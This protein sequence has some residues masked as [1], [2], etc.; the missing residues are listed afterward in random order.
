MSTPRIRPLEN[1]QKATDGD[2]VLRG[3]AVY[4]GI[5]G[6]PRFNTPWVAP[7]DLKAGVERLSALMAEALDGSKKI[8]AEKNNQREAVI[9]VLRLLGRYV[10]ITCDGDIAAFKSRGF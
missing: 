4:T 6:N 2:L 8:I 7:V 10:E 1:Y 9:K 5:N 3:T